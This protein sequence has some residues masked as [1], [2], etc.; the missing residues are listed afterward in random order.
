MTVTSFETDVDSITIK[1]HV[2]CMFVSKGY[3]CSTVTVRTHRHIH[4]TE[5][6]TMTTKVVDSYFA[7][8]VL[9]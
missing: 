3:S 6:S 7:F 9:R 5:C 1:L 8:Y 4:P 2:K